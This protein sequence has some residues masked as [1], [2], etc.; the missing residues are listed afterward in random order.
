MADQDLDRYKRV[1]TQF[2]QRIRAIAGNR[3]LNELMEG[4]ENQIRI[5]M[6]TSVQLPGR[7]NKSLAEHR[8]ILEAIA[9]GDASAARRYARQHIAKIDEAIFKTSKLWTGNRK[10]KQL[11]AGLAAGSSEGTVC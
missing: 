8:A 3:K 5:V 11:M 7:A 1:D 10:R 4:L 2:H 6:S 9:H